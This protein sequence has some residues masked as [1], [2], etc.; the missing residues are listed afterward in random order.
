M[1]SC[2]GLVGGLGLGPLCFIAPILLWQ[3]YNR[4]IASTARSLV[5]WTLIAVFAAVCVLATIGSV[6]SIA[7]SAASFKVFA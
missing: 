7:A 3:R 5:N 2:S 4:D 6:Y 1:S